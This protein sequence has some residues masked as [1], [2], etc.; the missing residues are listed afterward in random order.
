MSICL[1]DA[2]QLGAAAKEAFHNVPSGQ[3]TELLDLYGL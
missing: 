1:S 3:L 2:Q